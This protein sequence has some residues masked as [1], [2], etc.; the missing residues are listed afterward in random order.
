MNS[1]EERQERRRER[2]EARADRLRREGTAK[3]NSGM[4]DLRA[5]PF[6][7]P[8]LVGHHSENRDRNYRRKAINRV[9]AGISLQKGAQE[10][11]RRAEAVG[12]AGVSSD[13]PEA[14][15]KLKEKLAKLEASQ[16]MMVAANKAIRKGDDATL[17]ALGFN[18]SQIAK[19]KAPDF[20]GRIGFP[21]YA[22]TNNSAN[23]RRIKERIE[24]LTKAATRETKER[25]VGDVRIVENTEL[26]RLQLIFPDKPS[27]AARAILKSNGFRWSPTEKAWQRHLSG[28]WSGF[29]DATLKAIERLP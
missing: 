17:T 16:A 1:Y 12:T 11:A 3:I 8:I 18:E 20:C 9:N 14:V 4:T 15:T 2:L 24:Q 22:L 21:S 29:A 28:C 26:N 7:Q 6:G 10:A 5:I 19:L 13:D 23:M 25:M 27:E